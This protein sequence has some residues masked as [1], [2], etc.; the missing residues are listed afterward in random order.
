LLARCA[1]FAFLAAASLAMAATPRLAPST[2]Q[3]G[4]PVDAGVLGTRIPLVL[5]HGLGGD[6]HGW[7][8]LMQAYL[9]NAAWRSVFKPYSF[10]Y[11]SS[12]AD[13]LADPAGPRSISAL[14][15]A[16]R[17]ALQG[18]YDR[19]TGAPDYGF[20]NKHVVVL[21]HSMGGLV[22][23]SMMQEYVFRD[24]QRGGQKVLHLITLGTAHHGTPL[25]DAAIV[26]GL[27]N[28]LTD[29][30]FG[31]LADLAWTNFDG[32]DWSAGLCNRWLSR[33]NS[34]S[35]VPGANFGRCGSTSA[36][37]LPGYY[38]KIVAYGAA[39]LQTPDLQFGL[40]VFK[41]GSPSW[42]LVPYGLLHDALSRTYRNDGMV[43]MTSSQF[44]GVPTWQKKE[45]FDCDH[46]YLEHGY[47]EFVRSL[48]ATYSDWAFCAG[49]GSGASIPSG[50]PGGYA[51]S[52]SIYGV[53]GG[54]IDTITTVAN[55]ERVF[56]W[57]EQAF[58]G[59]LQP[60]GA[61]TQIWSGY[62][63]RHY[64]ATQSNVGVKDGNVYYQGPSTHNQVVFV[65]TV[66]SFLAQ[67]QA[68]GF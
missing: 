67:A 33:L 57:A 60:A 37:A 39:T 66:A 45:A 10:S 58:A 55:A 15:A 12:A 6:E 54:I 9:H 2:F 41:P 35:P 25:A 36:N 7:D 52:G 31:F 64:A 62:Y 51:V 65:A 26:L 32:M 28:E 11:S 44:D 38:E 14:G 20:G 18:Y 42:M 5:I 47:P 24:G 21:A 16:L 3:N 22:A 17:D 49:T 23:R 30:Y 61:S 56:D 34:Y 48:T 8:S 59:S 46:R 63:F 4:Q 53:P 50:I 29:G 1:L 19:P 40:G 27:Q 68:A 13:V 43:P